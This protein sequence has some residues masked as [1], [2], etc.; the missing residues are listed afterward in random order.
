MN[1]KKTIF[2]SGGFERVPP[3]LLQLL[4]EQRIGLNGIKLPSANVSD[5]L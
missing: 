4:K 2:V 1:V 3:L 5:G